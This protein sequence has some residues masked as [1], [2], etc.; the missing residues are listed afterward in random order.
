MSVQEEVLRRVMRS[1]DSIGAGY[2]IVF[3][4]VEYGNLPDAPK[5]KKLK[6]T[7]FKFKDYFNGIEDMQPGDVKSFPVPTEALAAFGLRPRHFRHAM[8]SYCWNHF[9]RKAGERSKFVVGLTNDQNS[10]EVYREA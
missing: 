4:G 5:T 6:R 8:Y 1:L 9:Q 2:K 3:D 10:V 7:G